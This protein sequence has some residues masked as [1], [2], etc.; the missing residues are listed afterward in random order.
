MY[1]Y[2]NGKFCPKEE[3]KISVFDHGLWYGNGVFE[4]I[5]SYGGKAFL[6]DRHLARLWDSA[7]SLHIEIPI[8]RDEMADAIR[9]ALL[10]NA[11]RDGYVRV[12]VTRGAGVSPGFEPS[13]DSESHVIIIA[14]TITL[15][16]PAA[17]EN[18]MNLVTAST[19]RTPDSA[20]TPRAK[21]LNYLNSILAKI[22]GMECGCNEALLLN[23][24][25]EVAECTADNLFVVRKG[26]V[27]TPPTD[28]GI[29]EGVTRGVVLELCQ[30][31]GI[32]AKES[33]LTRFDIY[34]ADECFI[35]GTA[36]ELV[37]VV[38]LDA[39]MIGTGS[40]GPITQALTQYYHAL[41]NA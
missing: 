26:V 17:Y 31:H 20:M 24:K 32:P 21:S 34:T 40:P 7:R 5:R 13:G 35:T 18:G 33:P 3:A 8:T 38:K 23:S 6:L 28:A 1:V 2:I 9:G 36:A 15:Y 39:R 16:P 27:C 29:L 11:I 10:R 12:V 30:E 25:G 4:G 37:P 14:E 22:E 19:I 41:A